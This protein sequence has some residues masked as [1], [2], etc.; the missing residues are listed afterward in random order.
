MSKILTLQSVLTAAVHVV[1]VNKMMPLVRYLAVRRPTVS[2]RID[3]CFLRDGHT[4]TAPHRFLHNLL[5]NPIRIPSAYIISTPLV[6]LHN[7]CIS[8]RHRIIICPK[9]CRYLTS[10]ANRLRII[11]AVSVLFLTGTAA[12]A[13]LHSQDRV[14]CRI[15]YD[16]SSNGLPITGYTPSR[17]H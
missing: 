9:F 4:G 3:P 12:V 1:L 13:S 17:D 2:Y 8:W 11:F 6:F 14:P 10:C 16:I 7:R 15:H 5:N